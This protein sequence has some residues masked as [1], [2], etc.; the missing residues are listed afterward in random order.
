MERRV[1]RHK[2]MVNFAQITVIKRC[3]DYQFMAFLNLKYPAAESCNHGTHEL[4]AR[5]S[6]AVLNYPDLTK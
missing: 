1:L 4:K 6:G 2:T 5:W 3:S